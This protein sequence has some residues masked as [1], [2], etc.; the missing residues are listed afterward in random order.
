MYHEFGVVDSI[1]KKFYVGK[2]VSN[3]LPVFP[4]PTEFHRTV[5]TRVE[6]YFKTKGK[7]P[8][9]SDN[10]YQE[11]QA[12]S[13][14]S[15]ADPLCYLKTTEP[16]RDLGTV[17]PHLCLFDSLV[18]CTILC[19]FCCRAHMAAGLFRHHYGICMCSGWTEPTSRRFPFFRYEMLYP[20]F[21]YRSCFRVIAN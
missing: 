20:L 3:E 2:L 8:K 1:M 14:C 4:E 16:A 13:R 18:H 11:V 21:Q 6:G 5:K 15:L 17:L 7:D 19:A 12:G 10:R 9:V